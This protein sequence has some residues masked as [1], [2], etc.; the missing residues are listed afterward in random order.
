MMPM[1]TGISTLTFQDP[2]GQTRRLYRFTVSAVSDS[3]T[4]GPYQSHSAG[5]PE[6]LGTGELVTHLG[7]SLPSDR[8]RL[9]RWAQRYL[10]LGLS[11]DGL[12]ELELPGCLLGAQ[13]VA[14]ERLSSA[15][16]TALRPESEA[17]R[18]EAVP[19]NEPQVWYALRQ[20]VFLWSL[21]PFWNLQPLQPWRLQLDYSRAPLG[22]VVSAYLATVSDWPRPDAGLS[23]PASER[24]PIGIAQDDVVQW[25]T[26]TRPSTGAGQTRLELYPLSLSEHHAGSCSLSRLG[27]RAQTQDHGRRGRGWRGRVDH[28][29]VALEADRPELTQ[30]LRGQA[31]LVLQREGQEDRRWPLSAWDLVE[32]V[33]GFLSLPEPLD[34]PRFRAWSLSVRVPGGTGGLPDGDFSLTACLLGWGEWEVL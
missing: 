2:T 27:A 1:T 17:L 30:A 26:V 11:F 21:T 33:L 10:R 12:T 9:R 7:L 3:A 16:P 14:P 28:L 5:G 8:P 13:G 29:G 19:D 18:L 32:G 20:P 25:Y 4:E 15:L 6:L 23:V 24:D 31:E 22:A 34:L